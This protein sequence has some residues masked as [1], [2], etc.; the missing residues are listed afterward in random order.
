MSLADEIGANEIGAN[1]A[2]SGT[3]GA[4]M[5][6]AGMG[7]SVS[8]LDAAAVEVAHRVTGKGP[9]VLLL[10]GTGYAGSTWPAR[11][12]RPGRA[13]TVMTRTT[14]AR[15]AAPARRRLLHSPVRAPTRAGC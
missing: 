4:T 12:S 6:P 9:P 10:A 7:G 3:G 13:F 15:A 1:E 14:G 5:H 8:D 2:G 11:S